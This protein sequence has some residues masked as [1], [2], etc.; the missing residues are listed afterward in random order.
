[1][2]VGFAFGLLLF[3]SNFRFCYKWCTG[4]SGHE[5]WVLINIITGW[6][7]LYVVIARFPPAMFGFKSF[8]LL[9]FF[10]F[11]SHTIEV[12]VLVMLQGCTDN[13]GHESGVLINII[14]DWCSLYGLIARFPPTM[15]CFS[16][17]LHCVLPVYAFVFL[18]FSAFGDLMFVCIAGISSQTLY[19]QDGAV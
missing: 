17:F 15:Y 18:P 14:A 3:K 5:S 12:K 8:F 13:S 4:N 16:F 9:P 6:C 19:R 11:W 1:M 2:K 10:C 7:S